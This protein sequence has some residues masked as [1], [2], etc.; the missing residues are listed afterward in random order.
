MSKFRSLLTLLTIVVSFSGSVFARSIDSDVI[1]LSGDAAPPIVEELDRPAFV[2]PVGFDHRAFEA[3]L[4]SIWFQRKAYIA[5]GREE[6][7][8]R[9][10]EALRSFC[11][12]EGLPRMADLG[13][14]LR[15]EAFTLLNEGHP[16]RAIASLE[17]AEY[18]D[19]GLPQTDFLRARVLWNS[20]TGYISVA[21]AFLRGVGR[22]FVE[23]GSR[24]VNLNR[25]AFV[26]L[27]G[28]F[29]GTGIFSLLMLWKYHGPIRHE[30]EE[31]LLGR[32]VGRRL[33]R[34]GGWAWL[35]LPMMLWVGA[36]WAV[37]FWVVIC[38]RH[39]CLAERRVAVALLLFLALI[40]PAL[41]IVRTGF[42]LSAD[43]R[44]RT[45]WA[46][47]RGDYDPQRIRALKNLIDAT[48]DDP[49]LHFLLADT[50]RSGRYLEQ[51]FDAYQQV[52][53]LDASLWQARMNLGN[54][55][56]HLGQY[57]GAIGEYQKTLELNPVSAAVL[58]NM[59]IAQSE[60]FNFKDAEWSLNRARELDAPWVSQEMSKR[61]DTGRLAVSDAMLDDQDLWVTAMGDPV[62][63][64]DRTS[65]SVA[66]LSRSLWNPL[67]VLSFAAL[68]L[69]LL[70][71][72]LPALRTT[73]RSC[74]RCQHA[75]CHRCNNVRESEE[76]CSQCYHLFVLK[77]G[78]AP[79]VRSD[80]LRLLERTESR[81]RR[82]L[83]ILSWLCP[84]SST[85]VRGAPVR[86]TAFILLW[87]A[88]LV[89]M[90][91]L[92]LRPW[93]GA[94]GE[95]SPLTWFAVPELPAVSVFQP[96]LLCAGLLAIVVW[97]MANLTRFR[98]RRI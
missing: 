38:Y 68:G 45:T 18:L 16:G 21:G 66:G 33:A 6:D 97:S 60:R 69:C 10:S 39:L 9:V 2:G 77:D 25:A 88:A 64:G 22:S 34:T 95:R 54:I 62:G 80:K 15:F 70:W 42:G 79:E 36:G 58:Y 32:D 41:Q 47:V 83:R 14:A 12:E 87:S 26:L 84:G 96:W 43:P 59:H 5:E 94:F 67:S 51:A 89:A 1:R 20:G 48:P 52:L 53:E 37:L 13:A 19:P 76:Y 30:V 86:G 56:F 4:E 61:D 71:A 98:G 8:A 31:Y 7:A 24:F 63:V 50:Y 35:G 74:I 90:D 40:V 85:L 55:Y 28:G 23:V 49:T 44:A 65:L 81:H 75:F 73:A 72:S 91:E 93:G 78:L 11:R 92:W 82:V 27:L 57:D 3:R 46:A 17:L 29:F